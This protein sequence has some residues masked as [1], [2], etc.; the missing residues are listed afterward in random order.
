MLRDFIKPW[1]TISL[2]MRQHT[3]LSKTSTKRCLLSPWADLPLKLDFDENAIGYI[4]AY[5]VFLFI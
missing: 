4:I 3:E 5:I 1:L 2:S